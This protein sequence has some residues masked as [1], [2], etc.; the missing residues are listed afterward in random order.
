MIWTAAT[1]AVA[2]QVQVAV[3]PEVVPGPAVATSRLDSPRFTGAASNRPLPALALSVLVSVFLCA[4]Q[5]QSLQGLYEQAEYQQRFGNLTTAAQTASHGYELWKHDPASPWHWKFRLLYAQSLTARGRH[6]EALPLLEE[7]KVVVAPETEAWRLLL[8]YDANAALAAPNANSPYFQNAAR[9]VE[10]SG[11]LPLLI[12]LNL[13]R[14]Y[15]AAS[16]Q[17][18][19][20]FFRRALDT[21]RRIQDPAFEAAATI[22][23]G[24]FVF[25]AQRRYDEAVTWFER[26][27]DIAVRHGARRLEGMAHG[28]IG[29]CLYLLGDIDRAL[30]ATELA[31]RIAE[32]TADVER[33]Y[34]WLNNIGN[35]Y[36]S[37]ANYRSAIPYYQRAADMARRAGDTEWLAKTLNN[38][39]EANTGAGD[40]DRAEAINREARVLAAQLRD[41]DPMAWALLRAARIANKRRQAAAAQLFREAIVEGLR[42][43]EP[44]VVWIGSAELALIERA[45][46]RWDAAEKLYQDALATVAVEENRLRDDQLRATFLGHLI[47][48]Y[49]EYVELLVERGE[50]E[51]ALEVAE[52]SRA[53]VLAQKLG[54][55]PDQTHSIRAGDLPAMARSS[56]NIFL[57]FWVAP[58]RS[59]LWV[60]TP[61]GITRYDLPPG[62]AI[63]V[64]AQRYSAAIADGSNPVDRGNPYGAGL[65]DI[66]IRPAEGK[67]P[68]GA[69]VIVI[70]DG[71]LHS[72]NF[73]TLLAG[74]SGNRYWLEEARIAVAPAIALLRN[75][76]RPARDRLL[77]IGDPQPPEKAFEPLPQ[78][79]NEVSAVSKHFSVHSLITGKGANPD[80]YRTASP[81]G[82]SH[83]HF[84]AHAV[85]NNE[86]PLNS[87]VILSSN[88]DRFKLYAKDVLAEPLNASLVALS[89]CHGAG[90][91]AYSGEGLMGFSWAFL[92]AGARRVVAGLWQ[93]DD[94]AMVRVMERLY[95]GIAAGRTP[96]ESLRDAKITLL[97]SGT[98]W[99]RPYYWGSL[100]LFTGDLHP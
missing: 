49:Q 6:R 56:G 41:K 86:S 29:W 70:P 95:A 84:A 40:L 45:Q 36:L 46:K 20:P 15:L 98:Q 8:L 78:L 82:F 67:I 87:A 79:K 50:S 21:A 3:G 16:P 38:L 14:G 12:R 68:K 77:F 72:L 92:H 22:D 1:E 34:R 80:A 51:R 81:Q 88:G 100:E 64:L 35:H 54:S 57:S 27:R 9:A 75:G 69:N 23:L 42:I 71:S 43:N 76:G 99:A 93:V 60:I 5:R 85:T 61:D 37:R 18:A 66:L 33:Q 62:P 19:E 13:R 7:P 30:K 17:E 4:C 55:A 63:D 48:L 97:Q 26:A 96:G 10:K 90:S 59:F 53:R 39:T 89:A 47:D 28:N 91:R 32:E 44:R 58:K 24:Y 25:A 74:P 73:E 11:S 94:A 83:I 52:A 2:G 65:Y 31:E